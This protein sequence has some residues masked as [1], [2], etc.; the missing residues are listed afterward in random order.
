MGQKTHPYGFRLGV[1]KTWRSR[2]FA[3]QD[4]AKLLEE[5][6]DLKDELRKRL[7]AAGVS[8]VEVDR[9]GNKLRITIRTSRPGIIIG[10]KGAEI[11][12]L[13]SELAKR[14]KREVFIDI[15]EVHK[16]EMDAQLVGESIALQL[17]KRVAFRRA[18]RKAVESAQ[19]FGCKGIKVRVSGRLNGAEIARSEWYLQGQLPLHTLRADIDYG[20]A[21]AH[22]TY[23]VIGIK[24]WVYRGEVA[25]DGFSKRSLRGDEPR[26]NPRADRRDRP[27][28][29]G[30]RDRRGP[31]SHSAPP[32]STQAAPPA[33]AAA[34]PAVDPGPAPLLP[35]VGGPGPEG[36]AAE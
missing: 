25:T 35:P 30:D 15:Q 29:G 6:L 18:M 7:K 36:Q 2:W 10:R 1:T 33:A 26:R 28:R 9:P 4:Y 8:S 22:T 5:D 31:Q 23:G 3:K 20:F 24:V 11:E 16:P 13:K 34:A 21:Q 19:R 17:E 27:E 12:K 32:A 14:T